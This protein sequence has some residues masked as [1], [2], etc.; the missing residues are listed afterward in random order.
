MTREEKIMALE[1]EV[2]W[3][4]GLLASAEY[5]ADCNFCNQACLFCIACK[6]SDAKRAH[7]PDCLAFNVD[8][9]VKSKFI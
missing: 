7:A 9:E 6:C 1:S 2:E 3:L 5:G 8:G 4:R